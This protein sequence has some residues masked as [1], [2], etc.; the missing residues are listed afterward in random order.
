VGTGTAAI[1]CVSFVAFAR[2]RRCIDLGLAHAL[3]GAEGAEATRPLDNDT[4]I[5][6]FAL[7]LEHLEAEFYRTNVPRLFKE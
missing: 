6:N 1:M 5:L 2:A 7:L 4:V 3:I